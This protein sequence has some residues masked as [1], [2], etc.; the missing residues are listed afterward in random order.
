LY[1]WLGLYQVRKAIPK[2]GTY[3]LE[4][5]N[6]TQLAGTYSGNR[7]KKFVERNR[8]YVLVTMDSKGSESSKDSEDEA[9]EPTGTEDEGEVQEE[10]VELELEVL[11]RG[12]RV[13]KAKR[14][15]SEL[16]ED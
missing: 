8:F 13:W 6:G 2:K 7:L 14:F 1:K 4:E 15:F 11:G 10:P 5:F 16:G 12:H 9:S 3:I